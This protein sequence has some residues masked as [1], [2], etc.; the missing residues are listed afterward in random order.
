MTMSSDGSPP[1]SPGLLPHT[2]A[3]CRHLM[4]ASCRSK[5]LAPPSA[6]AGGVGF[7]LFCAI[8]LHT[9]VTASKLFVW[10][11]PL[12]RSSGRGQAFVGGFPTHLLICLSCQ[13]LR[14]LAWDRG[15]NK[16]IQG[17][18]HWVS[19]WVPRALEWCIFPQPLEDSLHL[20]HM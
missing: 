3:W 8:S 12:F 11:G 13:C 18:P 17:T 16:K 9:A 7:P 15:D 1:C 2:P 6:C 5:S 10:P 4:A 20:S 19:S 14:V